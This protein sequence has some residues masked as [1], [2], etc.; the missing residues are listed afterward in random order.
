MGI[1]P[2]A[3][4]DKRATIA[5]SAEIGAWVEIG[6]GVK[7]GENCVVASHVVLTGQ[8]TLDEG[9]HIFPFCVLG[10]E[11][12]HIKDRGKETCLTL[13]ARCVIREHVTI[14]RGTVVG[15]GK[16]TLGK[17]CYVMNKS[18][19]AHDCR[20]DDAVIVGSSCGL[21]GHTQIGARSVLL[22][23]CDTQPSIK[24]G[25]DCYLVAGAQM[26]FDVLPL[27]VATRFYLRGVN[28]RGLLMRGVS[29]AAVNRIRDFYAN[30]SE[31]KGAL[32]KRVESLREEFASYEEL[33]PIFDFVRVSHRYRLLTP[34]PEI[35]KPRL[36]PS[37][38]PPPSSDP[39]P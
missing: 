29:R 25:E 16:T 10:T 12:E 26:Q 23:K 9:C 3:R 17:G 15:G 22:G 37:F 18:H 5:A 7:I 13:G 1:H 21:A 31:R 38:T 4:V 35:S 36:C 20:I 30:L 39:L 27:T 34:Y 33:Q 32:D 2:W 14:N 8:T 6:E 28:T 19:I 11:P 24:I